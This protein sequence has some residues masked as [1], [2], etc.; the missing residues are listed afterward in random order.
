MRTTLVWLRRDLRVKDNPALLEAARAGTVVPVFVW[1]PDEEG[2]WAPGAASRRWLHG[3]LAALRE[4]LAERGATLTVRRGPAAEALARLAR[5]TGAQAL[6]FARR[7][8]PAARRQEEE[9]S[10]RL[11]AAGAAVRA[12]PGDWLFEPD[13]VRGREGRPYR[14]FT[15][16]WNRCGELSPPEAPCGDPG[17]LRGPRPAPRSLAVEALGLLPREDWGA[18]LSEAPEP[19]EAAAERAL[20]AFLPRAR[21]YA[22]CRDVLAEEGSSLSARLHF[23]EL[24]VR[25]VWRE[26]APVCDPPFRKGGFLGE[27]G[28]R[29]F[30]RHVLFHEPWTPQ[31]P[32]DERFE[33]FRWRRDP[34]GLRAW[35]RG[36]TGFPV[37]DA[38]MRQLWRTG[39]M[40]NRA[41]MVVASFL[42]K[43][44]LVDWRE[45]A[46]WFW[47]ALVDADL[48]SNTLNWQWS[49]GCGVDAA[50]FFRVF[51]PVEQ[52]RRFDP[53]GAYVKRWVPELAR[54]DARW[55]H[56]PWTA[57][58]EVLDRAGVLLGRTYPRPVVDHKQARERALA[59]YGAGGRP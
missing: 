34:E 5:E 43:D 48:A 24:D 6:H 40:H 30:A 12:F 56:A 53:E 18:G 32:H 35:R 8:E 21:T 22:A 36:E 2:D 42:V 44:L 37:V 4:G 26:A 59:A 52:G 49:A 55:V 25:R 16:Y 54:L 7:V 39:L 15:P 46:R 50:P 10:S 11:A 29:D 51:N 28:W 45:G 31:R 1:S 9:V 33:G 14:V 3:S 17:L 41:R 23:G 27:L 58:G 20:A 38:G 13:G 57:P 19:G 47:D